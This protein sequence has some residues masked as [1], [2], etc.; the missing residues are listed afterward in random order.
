MSGRDEEYKL[1]ESEMSKLKDTIGS[2][3][4]EKCDENSLKWSDITTNPGKKAMIIGIILAALNQLCGCFAMLQYTAN[5]FKDAGSNMSPNMS[6]IFVGVI[7]LLGSYAPAYL[8]EKAGR[9]VI[10]Y[11]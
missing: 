5:I 2:G 10:I 11:C 7:Q 8:V 4:S 6:A 9:K 3:E 1:L